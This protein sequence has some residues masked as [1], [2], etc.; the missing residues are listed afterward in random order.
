LTTQ[1]FVNGV[2]LT[3]AAWFNDVD[4]VTYDGL[5]GQVLIGGGAGVA[6]VWTAATGT[7]APVRAGSPTLT[8]TLSGA[9]ATFSTTLGVTGVITATGGV[10][11]NLTGNASGTAATVTGAAQTAI[12]SVGSLTSLTMVGNIAVGLHSVGYDG[13]T[14]GLTFDASSNATFNKTLGVTGTC[15]FAAVNA[16]NFSLGDGNLLKWGVGSTDYLQGSSSTHTLNI[17]LNSSTVVALTTGGM[18]VTGTTTSSTG[19]AVGGATAGT[20]GVAFPSTQVAVAD[21]NTLDDYEEGTWTPTLSG[22]TTTT[23]TT[24]SG[25]YVKIGKVVKIWCNL[26]I[27]AVGNGSITTIAGLPFTAS[28]QIGNA[29]PVSDCSNLASNVVWLTGFVT[30]SASTVQFKTA[31]ISTNGFTSSAAIFGSAANISFSG[32]YTV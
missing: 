14:N 3:D 11:G 17:L 9:A 30:P 12:T 25:S 29:C 1:V 27:N 24:Q 13:S 22:A 15:T 31:T 6:A 2:T 20:G 21:V 7:G 10:V 19:M 26:T 4:S 32:T 5:T 16:T 8:G 23:Y 18:V 28:A